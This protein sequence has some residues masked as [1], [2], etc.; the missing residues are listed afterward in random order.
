MMMDRIQC[1]SGYA[2]S[3]YNILSGVHRNRSGIPQGG[4]FLY[5]DGSVIWRKFA[6]DRFK[7]AV[8]ESTLG[9]GATGND[10]DY[11]VPADLGYGPW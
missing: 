7:T 11:F 5:E 4:N 10:I 2:W 1:T 8:A 9:V 6:W 3:R